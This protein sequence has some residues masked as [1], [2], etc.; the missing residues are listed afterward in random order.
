MTK[1]NIES[2][3]EKSSVH[4]IKWIPKSDDLDAVKVCVRKKT[5]SDVHILKTNE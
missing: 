1:E 4:P 5:L 2:F 3:P